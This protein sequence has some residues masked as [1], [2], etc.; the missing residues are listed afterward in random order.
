MAIS[1]TE[2]AMFVLNP[3][4]YAVAVNNDV[5]AL[6]DGA[7]EVEIDTSLT[8]AKATALAQKMLA[9][10]AHPRIFRVNIEGLLWTDF[11]VGG[12][13]Q[14]QTG[15][16]HDAVNEPMKAISASIDFNEGISEIEV[17]G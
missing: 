15:L 14:W 7:K 5:L 13:P 11:F 6:N 3:Y 4:R 17:R 9:A 1:D 8:E 16:D 10:N 2:H 12:P